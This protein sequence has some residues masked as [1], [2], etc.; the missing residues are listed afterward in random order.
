MGPGAG[1][2]G[3]AIS[4]NNGAALGDAHGEEALLA[5]DT[6]K[7]DSPNT[8]EETPDLLKVNSFAQAEF[9]AQSNWLKMP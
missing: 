9:F 4:S 6:D 7:G 2:E 8:E 5:K 1:D 3:N